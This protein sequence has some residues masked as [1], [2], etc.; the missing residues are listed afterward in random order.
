MFEAIRA[1]IFDLDGVIR[2]FAPSTT[3]DEQ[4]GLRAGTV[5]STAYEDDLL[6]SVTTGTITHTVWFER[7]ERRLVERH[8]IDASGAAAQF[9]ALEATVDTEVLAFSNT[10]R[11][12]GIVTAVLTNGTTRVEAECARLGIPEHFDRFFNSARIGYAKPDRRVFE[13]A[14]AALSLDAQQCAFT[15]DSEYKLLGAKEIGMP[16][17][18][19][20]DL[21]G[22]RAW[23]TT[24]GIPVD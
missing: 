5:E 21:S 12:R 14:A 4:H 20:V 15:D 13:H 23:L 18:H 9:A 1:V 6:S 16:T 11:R 8:G 24:L 2:H 7:L 3:I 22:L 19:F 17:H 10:L